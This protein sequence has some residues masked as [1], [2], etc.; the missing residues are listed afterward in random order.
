M[1]IAPI[2]CINNIYQTNL[3][4]K[5]NPSDKKN[6]RFSSLACLSFYG[7][8]ITFRSNQSKAD[9]SETSNSEFSKLR[10]E[11]R[12][13]INGLRDDIKKEFETINF[14]EHN[15]LIAKKVLN[16][17]EI[18][19]NKNIVH[20][21]GNIIRCTRTKEEAALRYKA[22]E[23]IARIL[24]SGDENMALNILNIIPCIC[25]E[26]QIH[27]LDKILDYPEFFESTSLKS[28]LRYMICDADTK[29]KTE[30]KCDVIDKIGQS[31]ELISNKNVIKRIGD[32]ISKVNTKE[33]ADAKSYI[34]DEII[35]RGSAKN[36]T[37]ENHLGTIIYAVDAKFK[38]PI[39]LKFLDN[40]KLL[41]NNNV[42]QELRGIIHDITSEETA[43][44][45]CRA[46]EKAIDNGLIKNSRVS[47]HLG[48][49]IYAIY[50]K[51][52]GDLIGDLLENPNF[53]QDD[54]GLIIGNW[55]EDAVDGID[56]TKNFPE[57]AKNAIDRMLRGHNIKEYNINRPDI[58]KTLRKALR[59]PRQY[60][61][62]IP[63]CTTEKDSSNKYK[64]EKL[65]NTLEIEY[66]KRIIDFFYGNFK[67][68]S[69]IYNYLDSDTINSMMDKRTTKFMDDLNRLSCLT[70]KNLQL[71]GDMIN[72]CKTFKV[73]INGVSKIKP[74]EGSGGKKVELCEKIEVLQALFG[75]NLKED[76]EVTKILNKMIEEKEIDFDKLGEIINEE[77][78]KKAGITSKDTETRTKKPLNG[79]YSHFIALQDDVKNQDLYKVLRESIDG[80][81][82]TYISNPKT[83]QGQI[84]KKTK[85]EFKKRGLNFR[86]WNNPEIE[87]TFDF[88]D[89]KMHMKL[90]ERD[91]MEDLF[92]GNKTSCCTAIGRGS[93]YSTPVYLLNKSFNVIELKDSKGNTVGMS[94]VY[95]AE[96]EGV[97]SLVMDNIGLNATY[98][99]AKT[100]RD[101]KIKIRNEFFGFAKDYAKKV[102]NGTETPVYF[103]AN[104]TNVAD[105]DLIKAYKKADFIGSISQDDD[106]KVY[107]NA[108]K[109]NIN[110]KNLK[111][112]PEEFYYNLP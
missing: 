37:L 75:A 90:W 86:I 72:N 25:T 19:E 23:S 64:I 104:F 81:F 48:E 62:N 92:I 51:E 83:I 100:S 53:N 77:I 70:D 78:Y 14:N 56:Y 38:A 97:P 66:R 105:D 111:S 39:A 102:N 17:P 99:E 31:K 87:R 35:K 26:D 46:I 73:T 82:K 40:P 57:L 89:D 22:T 1:K 36:E 4:H 55:E 112:S 106:K 69:R 93:G 76:S 50:S 9:L 18:L 28:K 27:L 47:D 49:I 42:S 107:I 29:E 11:L 74:L 80:R 2:N 79:K 98:K 68:I 34:I 16:T 91:P 54:I 33:N 67:N 103:S 110:P 60:L 88:R 15:I 71:I 59:N 5:K 63:L 52:S 95:M 3:S 101:E 85:E 13:K 96:I 44:S 21:F 6:E 12:E 20:V 30:S 10:D 41:E 94:R 43:D 58:E 24:A 65:P 8:Y 108:C 84:N 45:I 61:D 32:I 7:K 109:G